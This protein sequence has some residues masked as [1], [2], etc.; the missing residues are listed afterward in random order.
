[1]NS[2]TPAEMDALNSRIATNLAPDQVLALDDWHV[3][4]HLG[5]GSTAHVWLLQHVSR[6]GYVACKTPKTYQDA[7][8]LSQEAQ[9]AGEIAHE[10]LVA[11]PDHSPEVDTSV[12]TFWEYLPAGSL[13]NLIAS[14]GKLSVAKTVTV[15]L[16]MLQ[17][18][19]YLHNHQIVHGD[20][21]PRNI[22]F[23]LTGKPVLIDLGATRATAHAYTRIGTP[24]FMPPELQDTAEQLAGLG[25]AADVYSLAAVAWFCLTA[26]I[27]G[28]TH[29]RVP[30]VTLDPELDEEI[31]ELLEASLSHEPALRPTLN[32][33]LNAVA[34]WAEPEAVD[35]FAAV[36]EEFE[37][38]LPTR[39]PSPPGR[40]SRR[41]PRHRRRKRQQALPR[42]GAKKGRRPTRCRRRIVLGLSVLVLTGGVIAT[43]LYGAPERKQQEALIPIPKTEQAEQVDFQAIVDSLAKSRSAAWSSPDASLVGDYATVGSEIFQQDTKVLESLGMAG[44]TLYGIRMRAVVDSADSHADGTTLTVEWRVDGYAQRDADGELV[45]EFESRID[46]LDV[47][48]Q[49]TAEGWKMVDVAAH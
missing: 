19:Q 37:L 2:P 47:T 3:I 12:A 26:T 38:L 35:L 34:H 6:S 13:A 17:V 46:M 48:L 22:L 36:D 49:N 45:E 11:R 32:T 41:V 44:H 27:P 42:V 16:P 4:R 10:N 9:L 40:T 21:S 39:K 28:P 29:S 7:E 24:G 8:S 20:I 33:L 31:V 1:M 14:G 23:D 18:V 30:L 43:A 5:S 15:F 25:T